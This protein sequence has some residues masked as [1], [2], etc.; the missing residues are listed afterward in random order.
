MRAVG[1]ALA[2]L[3]AS[4]SANADVLKVFGEVHGGAMG[5]KATSGDEPVQDRAFFPNAPHPMYGVKVAARFL[6]LEAQIQHHQYRG[7]SLA[8]WT[9]FSAG[10]G[11]GIDLGDEKQK[12]EHTST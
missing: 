7:D 9:Q 4:A 3:V 1:C 12:K 2:I 11:L 10:L 6:I 8:T 5:G